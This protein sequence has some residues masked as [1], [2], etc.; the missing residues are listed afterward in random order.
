MMMM[1]MNNCSKFPQGRT[2]SASPKS[3]STK[4]KDKKEA[5]ALKK[6]SKRIKKQEKKKRKQS[7]PKQK[8]DEKLQ[9]LRCCNPYC[10][11]PV[12]AL[13]PQAPPQPPPQQSGAVAVCA[14]C[15]YCCM[16]TGSYCCLI[17]AA[18]CVAC[19]NG[20]CYG[21]CG[22]EYGTFRPCNCHCKRP[23]C[24]QPL[25]C[26]MDVL[27]SCFPMRF[28]NPYADPNTVCLTLTRASCLP[29]RGRAACAPCTP[30]DIIDR[31]T[32]WGRPRG[33]WCECWAVAASAACHVAALLPRCYRLG[34]WLACL[35]LRAALA[36]W[37]QSCCRCCC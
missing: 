21:W 29:P 11:V 33:S 2:P 25:P 27:P 6:E 15:C 32:Y 34:A 36:A 30:G 14:Q 13:P 4:T 31:Y 24:P 16:Q 9:T 12:V 19:I 26:V 37:R 35:G 3:S 23:P 10:D 8:K 28:Y 20:C 18:G 22:P 7:K 1:M 17:A 5:K